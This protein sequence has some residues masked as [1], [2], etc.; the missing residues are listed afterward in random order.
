MDQMLLGTQSKK[1]YDKML[2]KLASPFI[3]LKDPSKQSGNNFTPKKK[4]RK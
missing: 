3:K 1:V 4:K 2:D